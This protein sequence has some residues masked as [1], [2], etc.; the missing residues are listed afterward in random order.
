MVLLFIVFSYPSWT[1]VVGGGIGGTKPSSTPTA[2][3]ELSN[4]HG[5]P[6]NDMPE[7]ILDY[8]NFLNEYIS[9]ELPEGSNIYSLFI[10]SRKEKMTQQ[11]LEDLLHYW[12]TDLLAPTNFARYNYEGKDD[13]LRWGQNIQGG[14]LKWDIVKG[15]I[16]VALDIHKPNYAQGHDLDLSLPSFSLP[17]KYQDKIYVNPYDPEIE[18]I[19]LKG[20]TTLDVW[21]I[22]E[23]LL[24][25]QWPPSMIGP[26]SSRSRRCY[27]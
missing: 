5:R 1:Q 20:N 21:D 18:Q 11:G 3:H 22:K 13:E 9:T 26:P 2:G 16:A 25:N 8:E 12:N 7:I 27:F 10:N 17:Y 4:F 24:R 15:D 19:L 14:N 6:W 23:S